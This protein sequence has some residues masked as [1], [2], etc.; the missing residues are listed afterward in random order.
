MNQKSE[1]GKLGE[2]LAC[3]YLVKKGYKIIERN[4]RKPWGELDI[5]AISPEKILVF[6]EVKT[7][8]KFQGGL[9]PEDQL[10]AAKKR[11][12]QRAASLYAGSH[13][14]LIDEEKGWRLDLIALTIDQTVSN[15]D[16]DIN[17]Y[18]NI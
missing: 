7:M 16:C 13:Q 18:Q 14:E 3:D 12:F 10:T 1:L 5:I 11:K 17:Y 8:K 2:D 6:C 9:R 15:K 4:F